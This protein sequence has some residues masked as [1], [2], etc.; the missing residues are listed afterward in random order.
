MWESHSEAR[1]GYR[2]LLT[3][4]DNY[5]GLST[6][7]GGLLVIAETPWIEPIFPVAMVWATPPEE[8]TI[9]EVLA[10]KILDQTVSCDED[11]L[12]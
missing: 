11:D 6:I 2:R 9:L 12:R 8:P 1:V 7:T 10:E 3:V 5:R 4:T